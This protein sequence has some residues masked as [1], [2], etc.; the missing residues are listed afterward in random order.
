MYVFCRMACGWV[1]KLSKR[2]ENG[3]LGEFLKRLFVQHK[4]E[5]VKN[6]RRLISKDPMKEVKK[7]K[8]RKNLCGALECDCC[9]AVVECCDDLVIDPERQHNCSSF[10]IILPLLPRALP[11]NFHP[12]YPSGLL[13]LSFS[14]LSFFLSLFERNSSGQKEQRQDTPTRTFFT[15][16]FFTHLSRDCLIVVYGGSMVVGNFLQLKL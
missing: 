2:F 10:V 15:C 5:I 9:C 4:K 6:S 13:A 3:T 1:E 12:F 11:F 16:I 14:L 7:E 8:K